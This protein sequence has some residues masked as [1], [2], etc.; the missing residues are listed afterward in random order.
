M[1][2]CVCGRTVGRVTLVRFRPGR[3]FPGRSSCTPTRGRGRVVGLAAARLLSLVAGLV[4]RRPA[5][6]EQF[7]TAN[8]GET[9]R[10][11]MAAHRPT[12]KI[13]R[14]APSNAGIS[15]RS[16]RTPLAPLG[17]GADS[18]RLT[19]P[20]MPTRR[21]V[22]LAG[23]FVGLAAA[24]NNPLAENYDSSFPESGIECALPPVESCFDVGAQ[25]YQG[26]HGLGL[27]THGGHTPSLRPREFPSIANAVPA[28][29]HSAPPECSSRR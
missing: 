21:V 6:A 14:V 28:S 11:H 20:A 18:V 10:N 13:P 22:A 23:L 26:A 24:C 8:L 16:W 17:A 9:A 15:C 12:G 2:A 5:T 4:P 1:V 7:E 25:N 19:T 29:T 27:S 3:S